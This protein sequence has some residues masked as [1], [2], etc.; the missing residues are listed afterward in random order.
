MSTKLMYLFDPAKYA[1]LTVPEQEKFQKENE[2]LM[3]AMEDAVYDALKSYQKEILPLFR[4][5]GMDN[6]MPAVSMISFIKQAFITRF[7]QYCREATKAR[8]RLITDS[9]EHIYLKKLNRKKRPQNIPTENNNRILYQV[10]DHSKTNRPNV[11]FGYTCTNNYSSITGVYAICIKGEEIVWVTDI[12]S[13]RQSAIVTSLDQPTA[14]VL[15]EGVVKLK[16]KSER[17]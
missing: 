5:G 15:K 6:N 2:N 9:G 7:P 12:S 1:R 11:F 8:F 3:F 10:T 4:R 17:E 16:S 13:L 14:P